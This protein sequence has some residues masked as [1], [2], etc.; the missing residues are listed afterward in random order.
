M[1]SLGAHSS[2]TFTPESFPDL[3]AC[4][5]RSTEAVLQGNLKERP[6]SRAF[7]AYAERAFRNTWADIARSAGGRALE[8]P[9]PR[10]IADVEMKWR[11]RVVGV[12]IRT[13]DFGSNRYADGGICSVANLLRYLENGHLLVVTE[14]GYKIEG[15]VIQDLRVRSAPMH[16]LP[17]DAY[18]I[19]NLGTGQVRLNEPLGALWE[20]IEWAR[21]VDEFTGQFAELA[22]S[23]YEHVA[24]VALE[25]AA[26]MEE[27]A[28][29]AKRAA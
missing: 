16:V 11:E 19:E 23:H 29:S 22:Q 6:D 2:H 5:D 14:V 3:C 15:G 17:S 4:V 12:D 26:R 7:G 25:R 8:K 10:H 13:K 18:R 28:N 27:L 20:R 9:G 1:A 24:Q 21:S